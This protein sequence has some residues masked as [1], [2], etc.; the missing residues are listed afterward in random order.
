MDGESLVKLC[1]VLENQDRGYK[2]P[3]SEGAML[4][5]EIGLRDIPNDAAVVLSK[6]IVDHCPVRPSV[7][8][9]VDLWW[10]I[11]TSNRSRR[12]PGG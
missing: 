11:A 10:Q 4:L 5:Y 1:V 12:Y 3:W 6:A 8:T 9:I 2:P 7:S